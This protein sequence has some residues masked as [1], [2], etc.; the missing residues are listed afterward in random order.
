MKNFFTGFIVLLAVVIMNGCGSSG[1]SSTDVSSKNALVEDTLNKITDYYF[2][3]LGEIDNLV[4]GKEYDFE[5]FEEKCNL[6]FQK[7]SSNEIKFEIICSSEKENDNV[8]IGSNT[9]VL[10]Y[11]GYDKIGNDWVK[12][13]YGRNQ[14]TVSSEGKITIV[15]TWNGDIESTET[16]NNYEG[17]VAYIERNN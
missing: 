10:D 4:V 1:G 8:V 15:Y 17:Y 12:S 9:I 14:I 3:D 16:F 6:V 2:E 7:I 11:I 5:F 13:Y